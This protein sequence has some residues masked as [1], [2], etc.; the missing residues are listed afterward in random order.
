[1]RVVT[2]GSA[3]LDVYLKSR[4]FKEIK[5]DK[6][7][8][9]IGECLTLGSKNEVQEIFVDT[10]G[11]A[12]NCAVSFANLGTDVSVM[13]RIG[14]DLFGRE[15]EHTLK[16]R[17]I[18]IGLL[19]KD[20]NKQTSYSTLLLLGSGQRSILV[21]RGASNALDFKISPPFKGGSRGG[22]EKPD[23]FYVSSLG[24][25]IKLFSKILSYAKKNK[26]KVMYNPGEGELKKG[27]LE[28]KKYFHGL[29]VLNLN[30]EEA[31]L[32]C[33]TKYE[34]MNVI[35]KKLKGIS[36]YVVITDGPAG[37][38]CL[39]KDELWFAPSLGTKPVNTTGAGDAFGS[40]FCAGLML[41][42]NIEYALRL[43]ILNSDGVIRK[44]GAKNGLLTSLPNKIQLN[45]VKIRKEK[46]PA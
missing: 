31:A 28:L 7:L 45:K 38:F 35:I 12:T 20:K 1:M 26:I 5:S 43:G 39:C 6:F 14:N 23:W 18:D 2:I 36:P 37:A 46:I 29:E 9:G 34:N 32:L 30:R 25:N 4:A 33:K 44:M 41:K 21:Y 13:A 42:N 27:L 3:T 16:E 11:G 15:V 8:T 22:F 17:K 10:G 19:Q 24:S 40:G